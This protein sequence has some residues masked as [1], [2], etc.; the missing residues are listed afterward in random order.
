MYVHTCGTVPG[1]CTSASLRCVF[2]ILRSSCSRIFS[3]T[4]YRSGFS[5]FLSISKISCPPGPVAET[6]TGPRVFSLPD[7]EA[8]NTKD[9]AP[10]SPGVIPSSSRRA[11][12][13]GV[14]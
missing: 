5:F 2:W 4:K 14:C 3:P 7:E 11:K 9:A 12:T 6:E 10:Q 13:R 8:K 1:T